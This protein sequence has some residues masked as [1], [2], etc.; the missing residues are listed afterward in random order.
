MTSSIILRGDCVKVMR[1]FIP[2]NTI[3]L[4]IT[5]PPYD[6]IRDYGRDWDLDLGAV[7]D[8]LHR[9]TKDGGWAAVVIQDGTKNFR[10]SMTTM[11]TAIDWVDRNGW[12]LFETIIYQRNGKPGGWWNTRFRVD[13][14]YILIF[15]KGKRPGYFNKEPLKIP[16][17]HAGKKWGGTQRKTDGSLVPI[18]PTVQK[19]T[20]CRGTIWPYSTSNS[21]G[22]KLKLEH[23]AT[24][25]DKL[26]RDLILCFSPP[27]GVVLDP[28]CGAATVG[29]ECIRQGERDFIGIDINPIY[30]A[31]AERRIEVARGGAY[32][33][34]WPGGWVQESF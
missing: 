7:G 17:L 26:A 25:P 6:A 30:C 33:G 16:A 11:R 28:M 15:F 1:D 32:N 5:S 27:G 22:D 8:E 9:V 34:A 2:D 29:V 21:E 10:K 12:N 23:P 13:H 24:F 4:T 3:D 19:D 31:L 18:N 20:K 14:E